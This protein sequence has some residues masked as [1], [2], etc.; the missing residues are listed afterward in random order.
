MEL[1]LFYDYR[2]VRIPIIP[3]RL[4]Q[5][6]THDSH[7]LRPALGAAGHSTVAGGRPAGQ[8][9]PAAPLDTARLRRLRTEVG[10]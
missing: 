7:E 9:V 3:G 4:G 1:L 5:I 10:L 2:V 6:E 8:L